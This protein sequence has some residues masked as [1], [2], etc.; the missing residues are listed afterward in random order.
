MEK[1]QE[2]VKKA[3]KIHKANEKLAKQNFQLKSEIKALRVF[4]LYL[5]FLLFIKFNNKHIKFIF[6]KYLDKKMLYKNIILK[7]I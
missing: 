1:H 5:L 2:D 7:N 6:K 4:Y 3:L